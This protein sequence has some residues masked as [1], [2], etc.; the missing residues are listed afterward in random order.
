MTS[1][2]A[3]R[4]L[5]PERLKKAADDAALWSS[6][7][8][9]ACEHKAGPK[10]IPA[11]DNKCKDAGKV[12]QLTINNLAARCDT[13]LAH[14][15]KNTNTRMSGAFTPKSTEYPISF[16][17]RIQIYLKSKLHLW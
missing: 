11:G 12:T 7:V 1:V 13:K 8:V 10:G 2:V 3:V 15:K 17:Q 14:H 6:C 5:S 4:H 9:G 16:N